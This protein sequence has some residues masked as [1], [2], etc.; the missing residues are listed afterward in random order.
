MR[1]RSTPTPQPSTGNKEQNSIDLIWTTLRKDGIR[2]QTNTFCKKLHPHILQKITH[3]GKRWFHYFRVCIYKRLKWNAEL[4]VA[5]H[6]A[7]SNY[8]HS[9]ISTIR[10][11]TIQNIKALSLQQLGG[12]LLVSGL[13]IFEAVRILDIKAHPAPHPPY[14]QLATAGKCQS[15]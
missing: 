12:N 6:E 15:A 14:V 7:Y 3:G 13:E 2:L 8:C 4:T 10:H 5:E 1:T 9:R 11:D